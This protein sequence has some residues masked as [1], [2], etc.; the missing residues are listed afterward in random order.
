[1]I[2]EKPKNILVADDSEFFRIQLSTILTEGG[3]K[4][5]CVHDGVEVKKAIAKSSKNI[6]LLILD[7]RMPKVDGF[8]VL[9]WMKENAYSGKFQVL[10]VTGV[11]KPYDVVG[12]LKPL[13]IDGFITKDFTPEQILYCINR[14]LVPKEVSLRVEPRFPIC[15]PVYYT[16]E[17]MVYAGIML[18]ISASGLF[19]HANMELRPNEVLQLKF[20]LPDPN[21]HF[22]VEGVVNWLTPTSPKSRMFNGAGIR[23]TSIRDEDREELKRFVE[24]ED[25]KLCRYLFRDGLT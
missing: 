22:D 1:M 4:V 3:H 8:E 12:R 10:A 16:V 24:R 15:I 7:L 2:T 23:F 14:I 6:D 19:L 21:R 17:D 18:N 13:G 5:T 20:T 25:Q 9:E 11:Y